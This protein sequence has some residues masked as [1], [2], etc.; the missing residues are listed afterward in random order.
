MV[1]RELAAWVAGLR[2]EDLSAD[3]IEE[4]G[5]AFADFLGECLF[6]GATQPW[7]QSIASFCADEGGRPQATII[8]T[9]EKTSAARAAMA[10]GTMAL[11]FELADFGAGGRYYPFTITAPLALAELRHRSGKELVVAIVLGYELLARLL[12]ATRDR[13]PGE[14]APGYAGHFYMP[15]VYGTVVAAAGGARMLG[16]SPQQ[17]TAA[18]GLGCAFAAGTFQG[19]EEGAWQRALNG[20]M[21]SERGTTAALLAETGFKATQMGLEGVQGFAVM[22]NDGQLNPS[23]LLDDLGSSW[24]ITERWSKSY[25]MNVTL[26]A[27]VEAL[28]Q[29]MHEQGLKHTDLVEID[30]AWQRVEE[31]LAKH[32]V[33]T[34]VG[35]QASLPFALAL[36]A[37]RGRVSVD[38][39]TD[40]TVADP[41]IQAM[42]S[43]IKVHQ[44]A[45][46]FKRVR[47]SMPGAVTVQT[48]DGRRFTNEVLYPKGSAR[49][50]MSETEFRAKFMNLAVRVLGQAQ[51]DAL[52]DR[53]RRVQDIE[54]MAT[55]ARLFSPA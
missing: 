7:G 9:G 23:I 18:L 43:K 27:P 37:V 28:L 54:D 51:S 36:A 30:A 35:A 11:G 17:T 1:T 45:A 50:R 20:G 55:L 5:R 25:P 13:V 46:L 2:Y 3:A 24:V 39:F 19:H 41:T 12:R 4:A 22:F 10:N 47:N 44:D 32:T 38:D 29:I 15:S 52:Y 21:A 16:L 14:G 31:F 53:A 34:I 33:T 8:A 40:E 26:H 49:N 42:M 6:V 48:T